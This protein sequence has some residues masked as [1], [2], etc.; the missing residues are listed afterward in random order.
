MRQFVK[1]TI[2]KDNKKCFYCDE[3]LTYKKSTIDHK[4]PKKNQG[5]NDKSNLVVCCKKC[6]NLKGSVFDVVHF[7]EIIRD[8]DTRDFYWCI[9][10]S[11]KKDVVKNSSKLIKQIYCYKNQYNQN[12]KHIEK[13]KLVGLSS[14][15]LS[16]SNQNIKKEIK[17]IIRKIYLDIE[18]ITKQEI[19]K[20]HKL[21]LKEESRINQ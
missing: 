20:L 13:L 6:N 17:K 3:P 11:I 1:R 15:K 4:V 5:K 14:D 16:N 18:T 10:Q 8:I 12:K 19:K 2:Y 7:K 21:K 9:R